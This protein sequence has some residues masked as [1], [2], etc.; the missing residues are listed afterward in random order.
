MLFAPEFSGCQ[1]LPAVAVVISPRFSLSE[2]FMYMAVCMYD[3]M[4]IKRQQQLPWN[5][6]YRQL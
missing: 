1:V 3:S 6:T 4:V 2:I 5:C